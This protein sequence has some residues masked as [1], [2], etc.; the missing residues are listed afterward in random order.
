MEQTNKPHYLYV[1]SQAQSDFCKVGITSDVPARIRQLQTGNPEK[2]IILRVIVCKDEEQAKALEK[3]F[4]ERYA[5]FKAQGEWFAVNGIRVLSDINFALELA[6]VMNSDAFEI[7]DFPIDG[8]LDH[9][10]V[11]GFMSDV[12]WPHHT[13]R[14]MVTA[15]SMSKLYVDDDARE[16]YRIVQWAR[17]GS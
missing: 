13:P 16:E 5:D 17:R 7:H 10:W 6:L 3:A 2:I 14:L 9:M 8:Q 15:E 11:N 12:F 1:I 4:H